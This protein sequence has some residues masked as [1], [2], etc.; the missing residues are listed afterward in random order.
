M[1]KRQRSI[2][3]EIFWWCGMLLLAI[4]IT[5]VCSELQNHP[6]PQLLVLTAGLAAMYRITTRSIRNG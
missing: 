4:D 5:I 6:L 2:R 3:S 1:Y